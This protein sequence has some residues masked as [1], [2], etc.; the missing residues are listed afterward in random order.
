MSAHH[1]TTEHNFSTVLQ[2]L[3]F[4]LRS[5]FTSFVQAQ[6]L[7]PL[8]YLHSR[9][10]LPSSVLL[11]SAPV[12]P[13]LFAFAF[14]PPSLPKHRHST[15]SLFLFPLPLL[16]LLSPPLSSFFL[17]S[18]LTNF[19]SFPS[20]LVFVLFLFLP[21]L[22]RLI[23]P[24]HRRAV[25]FFPSFYFFSTNCVSANLPFRS[26]SNRPQNRPQTPSKPSKQQK[27]HTIKDQRTKNKRILNHLSCQPLARIHQSYP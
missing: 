13:S 26:H 24:I 3:A 11:H 27:Q 18:F 6:S 17:S 23:H 4:P 9:A 2:C 7:L 5:L 8:H 16:L 19:L 20:P 22:R 14:C 12:A 21:L 1:Y 15:V 10:C 25:F